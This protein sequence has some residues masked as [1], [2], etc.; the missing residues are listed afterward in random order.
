MQRYMLFA[1]Q[2]PGLDSHQGELPMSLIV[3]RFEQQRTL[4]GWDH[5]Q[6]SKRE[7]DSLTKGT[8]HTFRWWMIPTPEAH[9][10]H[11]TQ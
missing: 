9:R 11:P 8:E 7:S 4:V 6:G 10:P 5:S 3:T 1:V 2:L